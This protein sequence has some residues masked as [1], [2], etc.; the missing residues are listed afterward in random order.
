M[1]AS[2]G[3]LL[4]PVR[5]YRKTPGRFRIPRH[6]T[7]APHTACDEVPLL[8]LVQDLRI[9][10]AVEARLLAVGSPSADIRVSRD[11]RIRH[12]EGYRL[13]ISHTGVRVLSASDAGAYY[14][15]QTLRELVRQQGASLP[16]CLVSDSPDF[17]RRGVYHDCSRGKV[18]K[19][20]TLFS[21]IETLAHWKIN[22]LQ[23]YIENVFTFA[24]H[25]AI[26]RGFSPFTPDD[27]L[28]LQEHCKAHHVRFVPSLASFGHMETI[29]ALP[30]YRHLGE[31]PGYCDRPGGTT[32]FP[33]DRKSI[34]LISDLYSDFLPLF[35]SDDFNVCCDETWELG[36]GRSK[37][38]ASRTGVGRIYVDFLKKI[39]RLCDKHGKRMNAWADIVLQYPELLNELP[40]D[41]VM[42]NWDYWP[43][44][45]RIPRTK[46]IVKSGHDCLACPSVNA[47]A[48]HGSRLDVS[49]ANITRFAST[50]RKYGVSG[51]LN[52]N[53][54]D[55]GHRN[56]LA[57]SLHGFAH[58][59]AHSWNGQAVDDRTFTP[60]FCRDLLGRD[61]SSLAS[62]IRTLGLSYKTFGGDGS[63]SS[64]GYHILVEPL[65]PAKDF[66]R[67]VSVGSPVYFPKKHRY[68]RIDIAS[69][70]GMNNVIERL[71][72]LRWPSPRK[73]TSEFQSLCLQELE[74]AA[75]MEI[76][77][78]R[79]GIIGKLHR[80][81]SSVRS[82]R[83]LRLSE[84]M[85]DL[86]ANFELI[87]RRGNRPSR[88][89]DNLILLKQSAGVY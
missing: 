81:G 76:L 9:S 73:G 17:S 63:R 46:D 68:S 37:G 82:R 38:R 60:L 48:T 27:M 87:W 12:Q 8:Q 52:T 28:R 62:S 23:L 79:R 44:G 1:S 72:A 36:K 24:S 86:I 14:G 57:V 71:S 6:V 47:W 13:E 59:A 51:I 64:D 69:V 75:Q 4:I 56:T 2:S 16:C 41:V 40:K 18:P 5:R 65:D 39:H 19:L 77:A 26:G 80:A 25:P 83:R 20:E 33:S 61:H 43:E 50:A 11:G 89:R 88:L 3:G 66:Y 54:G 42:L 67:K 84:D 10:C 78:A 58:G 21:L 74:L 49:M 35:D 22:E 30:Q 34:E 85:N 29:L 31:M 7:L 45:S 32:L 55:W 70:A 15:L 53:W